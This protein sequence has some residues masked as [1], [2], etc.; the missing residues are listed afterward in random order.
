MYLP[1]AP[2]GVN[3][4]AVGNVHGGGKTNIVSPERVELIKTHCD[5][6]FIYDLLI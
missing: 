4:I 1:K 5:K 2:K 6:D 3:I